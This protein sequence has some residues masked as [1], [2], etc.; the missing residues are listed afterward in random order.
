MS[1]KTQVRGRQRHVPDENIE[2]NSKEEEFPPATKATPLGRGRAARTTTKE[3]NSD[4]DDA[5]AAENDR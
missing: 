3:D 1:R 5:A 4:E 2:N